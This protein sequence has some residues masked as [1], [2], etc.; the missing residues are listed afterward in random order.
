M[1]VC[2]FIFMSL[3]CF[4]FCSVAI[5]VALSVAVTHGLSS[6]LLALRLTL[7]YRLAIELLYQN[8]QMQ[9]EVAGKKLHKDYSRM[10]L[11]RA[12]L[13]LARKEMRPY[14]FFFVRGKQGR[15]KQT[16]QVCTHEKSASCGAK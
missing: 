3:R 6:F 8:I 5:R 7:S 15:R 12:G 2:Y 4:F 1:L 13:Q 11:S 14:G 9:W 16:S 10:D